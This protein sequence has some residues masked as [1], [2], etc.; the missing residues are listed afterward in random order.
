MEQQKDYDYGTLRLK[1]DTIEFLKEMKEAFEASYGKKFT[2]DE[3]V[4]QMAAAVEDG[5][6]GVWEIYCTQ[7]TQK[8]ELKKKVEASRKMREK[9]SK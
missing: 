6:P 7:Q 2:M 4:R 3:Y 5:D 1:R 9:K 8:E